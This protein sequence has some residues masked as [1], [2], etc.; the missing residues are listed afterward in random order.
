MM[1]WGGPFQPPV[2]SLLSSHVRLKDVIFS[3]RYVKTS[4]RR[5]SSVVIN[6]KSARWMV[7]RTAAPLLLL[8]SAG[9]AAARH[10]E[11]TK[12]GNLSRRFQSGR[13]AAAVPSPRTAGFCRPAVQ[14]VK[15]KYSS[16]SYY[17]ATCSSGASVAEQ[18]GKRLPQH[19]TDQ[20]TRAISSNSFEF[21]TSFD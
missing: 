8:I 13:R 4:H 14:L 9:G 12:T 10:R 6:Y 2:M 5:R 19:S 18:E 20:R 15:Y 7:S 11:E 16:S 3:L 17:F 21:Q 1:G